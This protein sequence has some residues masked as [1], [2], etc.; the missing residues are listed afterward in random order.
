MNLSRRLVLKQMLLVAGGATLL[1]SC[2]D[3]DDKASLALKHIK[4]TGNE[5][6]LLAEI[7]ETII[8]ST[9]TPGAK[10]LLI[11]SF[12]LKMIDDCYEKDKQQQFV[13][14]LRDFNAVCKQKSGHKFMDCSPSQREEILNGIETKKDCPENVSAFY[15]LTK[16]LTIRGYMSSQYVMTKLVKYELVPGRF[17][18]SYPVSKKTLKV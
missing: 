14:G 9:E 3:Q 2:F 8:P 7:E 4:L 15:S 1:P 16:N 5:E 13:K 17:H 12:T 10:E 11:P 6:K 18:G